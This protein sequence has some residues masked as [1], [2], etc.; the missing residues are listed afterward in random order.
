[1][2]KLNS[3]PNFAAYARFR[4]VYYESDFREAVWKPNPEMNSPQPLWQK[5]CGKNISIRVQLEVF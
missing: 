5:Y 1:M 2:D 4:R 3:S